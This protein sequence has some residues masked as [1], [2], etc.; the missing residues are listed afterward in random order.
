[1]R[2]AQGWDICAASKWLPNETKCLYSRLF[3]KVKMG[4]GGCCCF[5]F[6]FRQLVWP[7]A[8]WPPLFHR[9]VHRC[10]NI[11]TPTHTHTHVRQAHS[12]RPYTSS[13]R[14]GSELAVVDCTRVTLTNMM[15]REHMLV[16]SVSVCVCSRAVCYCVCACV[17]PCVFIML[18]CD[19]CRWDVF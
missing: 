2:W 1:M 7:G 4:G 13:E 19:F 5:F 8:I 6:F 10:T 9:H 15:S 18:L 14:V 3:F 12:H 16:L 11:T 17:G